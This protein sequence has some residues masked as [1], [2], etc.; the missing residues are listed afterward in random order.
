MTD[1]L[2][3][4]TER[5][6]DIPLLV[7]QMQQMDLPDLLDQH[8]IVHGNRQ[9]LPLGWTTLIWVAH[10]LS[11]ADHRLNRV[12]PWAEHRLETLR[13]STQ[14]PVQLLD[15]TDDR[16]ADVLR[17]LSDDAQWLTFERAL[18]RTLL[19][20]Y[21]LQP[22]RLRLDSTT[23]KSYG[24]VT[25]DGLLQFGHSKD[26]RPDLPQLKIMIATLDPLGLPLA[27]TVLSGEQADDRLYLPSIAE[28]R[29]TLLQR[30]LLYVGDCKMAA[31]ATR[32]ALHHG[33]DFYLCPLS[34][35][36]VPAT[37][38][39]QYLTEAW[40]DGQAATPVERTRADGT[41]EPIA[42]GYERV[43]TLR[44]EV[45][46]VKR[47]WTE[48]R[49]LVRSLAQGR[50]Q[51]RALTTRLAQAQAV[52]CDLTPPR[53]GKARL[54]DRASVEAAVADVLAQYRVAGLL[55]VTLT[56]HLQERLVR[57]YRDR[58]RRLEITRTYTVTAAVDPLA[59]AAAVQ[60]LGWR[61]YATNQA[62]EH[63]SLSQAVLA[64]RE[65]Y[66]IERD[67][68]RLKGQPLSLTPMYLARDDHTTGLVRLLTIAVRVLTLLE[69]SVRRR[70]AQD[71]SAL[72]GLY[73]GNP[74][75]TTAQPTTERLL[76]AFQEITLTVLVEPHQMRC[77]L[78]TLSALQQRVLALL[79]FPSEIY[80]KLG[81]DFSQPP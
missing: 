17:T 57:A 62:A 15:L 46:G 20:V 30:G 79:D 43:V 24:M 61:V 33:H 50:A 9:G 80:T 75:R 3:I 72:A 32:A 26:H 66:L 69:F 34:A 78:T 8:F 44:A 47:T 4:T 65:E 10:L 41:L 7:A 37:T 59:V 25:D 13:R 77:H 74:K 1:T 29:N 2:T 42:E 54:T 60:R 51:E 56:E 49:L 19:R 76:E 14:Q 58:P 81:R 35:V 67:F 28:V 48:R 31:L 16:L 55:H 63:L 64:Y 36:Q 70:L 40:A 27:T 22:D 38:L 12:Q 73:A 45:A 11:Q 52:V 6:D 21:D 53:P 18:T 71:G 5:V 39:E 68:G 23:A